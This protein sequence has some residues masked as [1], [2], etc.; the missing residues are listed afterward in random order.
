MRGEV[1]MR[2]AFMCHYD[3]YN[4]LTKDETRHML[5]SKYHRVDIIEFIEYYKIPLSEVIEFL[6]KRGISPQG[7]ERRK[8]E[9]LRNPKNRRKLNWISAERVPKIALCAMY[10]VPY[11]II[12][13]K[14]YYDE[15]EYQKALIDLQNKID[16][17]TK[18]DKEKDLSDIKPIDLIAM[19]YYRRINRSNMAKKLNL[20]K[21]KIAEL[22]RASEVTKETERMYKNE[23]SVTDRHIKQLRKIMNGQLKRVTESR[24]IPKLVK[25]NVF[26]RDGGRCKKCKESK[27]LHYHHIKKYSDGG[28]NTSDNLIL[29]CASCHAEEHKEDKSYHMLKKMAEE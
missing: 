17:Y 27:K 21:K 26:T 5:R 20:T 10:N 25:L 4:K 6:R 9:D 2:Y 15:E 24:S 16:L 28:E 11:E 3:D 19:R 23:L 18:D 8:I 12:K 29:L 14:R 22:E 7:R 1:N 13:G